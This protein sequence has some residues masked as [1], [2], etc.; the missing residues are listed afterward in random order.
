MITFYTIEYHWDTFEL[1]IIAS[2]FSLMRGKK[3]GSSSFRTVHI[4]H[5]T[6][7]MHRRI[8][9]PDPIEIHY[10]VINNS[11]E[12]CRLSWSGFACSSAVP[13]TTDAVTAAKIS[14]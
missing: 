10:V 9:T 14:K 6:R 4:V 3:T 5:T 8:Y 13:S 11:A 2:E 12:K 1:L 7:W